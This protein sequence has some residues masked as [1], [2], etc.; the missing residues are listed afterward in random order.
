MCFNVLVVV[1]MFLLDVSFGQV[2]TRSYSCV[3]PSL[4]RDNINIID[5]R[6]LVP[7]TSSNSGS[8]TGTIPSGATAPGNTVIFPSTGNIGSPTVNIITPP[9]LTDCPSGYVRCTNV[10][11]GTPT[12]QPSQNDGFATPGAFPWQAFIRNANS[13]VKNGYAGGGVLIDQYHVL[14]AAHKI[15]NLSSVSVTMGLY[16]TYNFSNTQTSQVQQIWIH[17]FYNQ[18]YLKND[19]ALLRLA[20]PMNLGLNVMPICLSQAGRSYIGSPSSACLVSGWGQTNFAVDDAPTQTLKQVHVPI[21]SNQQCMT[22]FTRVLGA[23]YATAY[24]DFPNEICAG[25]QAQQ[26]AC[27]QDG[28]SPLICSDT[29]T[30]FSLAGLVLWGKNCGQPDVYG[31][32]LN[33]PSYLS[34]IQCTIQCIQSL[35]NCNSCPA[36]RFL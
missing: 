3:L 35:Q 31:V 26:D 4:C 5:P 19:V 11:C 21:V 2:Q 18:T 22:S 6:I 34:W 23:A 29:S 12:V 13:N 16:N 30:Q 8:P 28:G 14:T 10:I 20:T 33:V 25:G 27:T 9:A 15:A 24:L 1:F 17:S 7:G 32:Y 36:T